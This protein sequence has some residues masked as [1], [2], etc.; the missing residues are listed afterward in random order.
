MWRG[1]FVQKCRRRPLKSCGKQS[2]LFANSPRASSWNRPTEFEEVG[3]K[4]DVE[5][6]ITI[7]DL[8]NGK[9]PVLEKALE[10]TSIP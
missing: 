4:P 8:R 1:C 2:T 3:I 9:D 10:L 5:V 6:H 7:G